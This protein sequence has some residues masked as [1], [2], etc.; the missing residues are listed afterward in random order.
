MDLN[1]LNLIVGIWGLIWILFFIAT[2]LN[3][4]RYSRGLFKLWLLLL[5]MAAG[6]GGW[7]AMLYYLCKD[8]IRP[9]S[10]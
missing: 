9:E 2:L 10:R 4:V 3:L 6:P 8:K 7:L 1:P 5:I